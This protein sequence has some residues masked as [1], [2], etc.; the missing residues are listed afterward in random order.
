M[1]LGGGNNQTLVARSRRKI[2]LVKLTAL[3]NWHSKS[4]IQVW[5]VRML[6]GNPLLLRCNYVSQDEILSGIS[7]RLMKR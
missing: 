2:K 7:V 4:M 5:E 1:C 6:R 3:N